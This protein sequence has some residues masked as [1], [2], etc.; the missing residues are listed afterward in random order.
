MCVCVRVM[1]FFLFNDIS[2]PRGLFNAK[3]ILVEVLHFDF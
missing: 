3:A 1:F 2:N